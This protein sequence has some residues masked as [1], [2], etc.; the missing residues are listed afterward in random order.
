MRIVALGTADLDVRRLNGSLENKLLPALLPLT[1]WG[2]DRM[3]FVRMADDW[4]A[5][6]D[7]D[8]EGGDPDGPISTM[9]KEIGCEYLQISSIPFVED[10]VTSQRTLG[11]LEFTW[12]RMG[13][14]IRHIQLNEDSPRWELDFGGESQP[15]EEPEMYKR[16]L[17][18]ERFTSDM[19]ERYCQAIGVD[20]FN[21]RAYGPEA[22]LVDSSKLI[23]ESVDPLRSWITTTWQ[24]TAERDVADGREPTSLVLPTDD[25]PKL[26]SLA[27][28]QAYMGVEPGLPSRI[29]G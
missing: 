28:S 17:I 2:R 1:Q 5:Y 22:V 24:A 16:R 8:Y 26:F 19:L 14:T 21:P 15:F 23:P 9:G 4:T 12:R 27:E 11:S 20:V 6:F 29:R 3:L 13:R 10:R 25:P 7:S 18:R